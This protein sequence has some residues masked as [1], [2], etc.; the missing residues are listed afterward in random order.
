M[1]T[2]FPTALDDA[3]SLPNPTAVSKTNNPSHASQHA[4]END[5]IKAIEAKIGTGS[6]TPSN[7]TLLRGNGSGTSEWSALTSAQLRASISDET[8]TGSAVFADTPTLTTPKV[9]TINEATAGVGVTIDGVL[10]KDNKMNGSYLTDSTVGNTQLATGIPVQVVSTNSNTS[11]TTTTLLPFDDTIPQNTEG[12][13]LMTQAIT[14][15]SATNI[16]LIEA[17]FMATHSVSTFISGA[18]FQD[19]IV[20][21]IAAN[22][23]YI[24]TATGAQSVT[25]KHKMTAGTTSATTFKLRVGGNDA[26]T[27]TFN[28]QSGNRRFGGITVSNITITEYKA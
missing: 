20:N 9:D 12:T 21:A 25:V 16:L 8:G 14:P 5:A 7:N 17:V 3:V 26:G 27:L 4:N 6:S 13:E 19:T 23:G 2:N 24:T 1:S 22:A 10:L 18:L 28:G 15:E 11:S